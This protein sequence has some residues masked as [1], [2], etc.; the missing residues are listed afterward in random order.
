[1]APWWEQQILW[2]PMGKGGPRR[3]KGGAPRAHVPMEPSAAT[4]TASTTASGGW[5]T[6]TIR[7]LFVGKG[8]GFVSREEAKAQNGRGDVFLHFSDLDGGLTSSDLAVGVRVRFRWEAAK[9]SRGPGGRARLVSLVPSHPVVELSAPRPRPT[10]TGRVYHKDTILAMRGWMHKRGQVEKRQKWPLRP[11][12][13][14]REI[15][16]PFTIYLPDFYWE[17]E[18]QRALA[19]ANDEQ[20]VQ[21]LEA[22]LDYEGGADSNN[23]ET[24][25]ENWA[26]ET[27]SYEDAV[28]AN[29]MIRAAEAE[30]EAAA[31]YEAASY[32]A[33]SYEYGGMHRGSWTWSRTQNLFGGGCRV[34][35]AFP[36]SGRLDRF[37]SE[38]AT[39]SKRAES[40][41]PSK[42]WKPSIEEKDNN[43]V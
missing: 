15:V 31:S 3:S 34:S 17:E 16:F 27:W 40:G 7:R 21:M 10:R 2:G 42:D 11:D 38:S 26:L 24:F 9:D 29:N 6:G 25:G 18:D 41:S 33:A 35:S 39:A 22:R 28:A 30:A 12:G 37:C 19:H 36:S 32:E 5:T 8:F 23:A 43:A 20:R 13:L 4:S 1:M 14:P